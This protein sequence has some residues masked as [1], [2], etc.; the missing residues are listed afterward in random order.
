MAP[1]IDITA[2]QAFIQQAMEHYQK[3]NA[4][5]WLTD[6]LDDLYIRLADNW[7]AVTLDEMMILSSLNTDGLWLQQ[8]YAAN[9]IYKMF[10]RLKRDTTGILGY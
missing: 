3:Q 5:G 8:N 2:M 9:T 7:M 10:R 4:P 1:F 6:W